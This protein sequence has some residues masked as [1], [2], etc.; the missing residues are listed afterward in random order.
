MLAE[1]NA[2]LMGSVG[3]TR[4]GA[5]GPT[6]RAG[7]HGFLDTPR[8][9]GRSS[10]VTVTWTVTVRFVQSPSHARHRRPG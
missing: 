6:V 4:V 9:L 1:S 3:L 2:V 8:L 7:H 10:L 5:T